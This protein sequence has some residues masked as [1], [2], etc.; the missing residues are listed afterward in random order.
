MSG[1]FAL[2]KDTPKNVSVIKGTAN[3]FMESKAKEEHSKTQDP[4]LTFKLLATG[5]GALLY[6]PIG[7]VKKIDKAF[8]TPISILMAAFIISG[9]M[10]YT[11]QTTTKTPTVAGTQVG[12]P[13]NPAAKPPTQ[14]AVSAKDVQPLTDSDHVRGNKD[15]R[16]LLIEY[17][18]LECPFCKKFHPT[19]QQTL[20]Q[21]KDQV[22]WVYR[23][24]PLDPIHSKADKEAEAVECAAELGG[25]DG[26]WKLVDKIY[27]VTP[28]NNGLNLD[29]LPKLAAEV[30]L[31]QNSFKTCL[32]SGKYADHVEADYQGGV[33]S[34]ISGT[35]GTILLDKKT[36]KTKLVP[37]AVSVESLKSEIDG[38]LNGS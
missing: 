14:A 8:L 10:V 13:T 1:H 25:E 26:F 19:V 12:A 5:I 33:K 28:S 17:S 24:F 16:I 3:I 2:D 35:P 9:S 22:A 20:E 36:S 6:Y 34:G 29:D 38:L 7:L 27:E 23:H 11:S 18:D 32:D 37:G 21:Y 30:G 31:N 4:K 15:A